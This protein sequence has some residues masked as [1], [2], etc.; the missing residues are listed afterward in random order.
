M[1]HAAEW[2]VTYALVILHLAGSLDFSLPWMWNIPMDYVN[3]LLIFWV[4]FW[5]NDRDSETAELIDVINRGE[6]QNL[7]FV[8]MIAPVIVAPIV[9]DLPQAVLFLS[10]EIVLRVDT[11]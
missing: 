10:K 3:K 8:P 4:Y 2:M 5:S 1:F 7:S 11:V 9:T 6:E